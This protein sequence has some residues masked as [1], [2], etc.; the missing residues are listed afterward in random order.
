MRLHASQADI[1]TLDVN[2]IVNAAN[3]ELL[4]GGGVCGAIHRT[5]EPTAKRRSDGGRRAHRA[6]VR[7]RSTGALSDVHFRSF[8]AAVLDAYRRTGVIDG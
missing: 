6:S 8:S 2:A 1:T 5:A 3:S 4:P 7:D